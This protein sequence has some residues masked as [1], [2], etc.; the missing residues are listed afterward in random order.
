M[1]SILQGFIQRGGRGEALRNPNPPKGHFP[2]KK[3]CGNN[4]IYILYSRKL[5]REKT[6]QIG[7]KYDFCGENFRILL[8]FTVPKDTTL[9]K[10]HW[11]NFLRTAT[12]PQTL[13]KFLPQ[14]FP[15]I[16]YYIIITIVRSYTIW[17]CCHLY[18]YECAAWV[19]MPMAMSDI[20]WYSLV[21]RWQ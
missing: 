20:F 1:D 19:T 4:I 2:L 15:T 21:L 7:E 13:R 10:F 6:L 8:T 18:C 16:P 14:N 3:D 17:V 11:K 9:P 12:K 5:S